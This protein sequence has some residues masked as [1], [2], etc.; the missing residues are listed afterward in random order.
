MKISELNIFRFT[1]ALRQPLVIGKHGLTERTGLIVKLHTENDHV[2]LGEI[3]P[4]PGLSRETMTQ[5]EAEIA[6]LRS[7]VTGRDMPDNLEEL[8]GGFDR[9]L[10]GYNMAPSVRFGFETACLNLMAVAQGVPLC[11]LISE[12]SRDSI[13][14]N[15][16]LTGSHNEIMDK[17]ARLLDMGY[18]AFK[19][20]VGRSSVRQDAE[21][22]LAIRGLI[23]DSAL[24]RLDANRAW[25]I[26]DALAFDHAVAGHKIDYIEEPVRSLSLLKKLINETGVS[27]PIALDESLLELTSQALASLSRIVAIVLKPTL[28][29]LEKAVQV[30][31]AATGLGITPVV[32]SSFESGVGLKTLAHMAAAV[33]VTDV[34]AGL[35]T[36]DWFEEDLLIHP[37][38]IEKGRLRVTETP[39][40]P[41][42][43]RL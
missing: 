1:L 37:L 6:R 13:S 35:D 29:G 23:G 30:A 42:E 21:T 40:S 15:G 19:L 9:W 2:A 36:L 31:R 12:S 3:S 8:S 4:L 27:L 28:W 7:L 24:L 43:I 41:F 16:L 39:C 18:T 14:V 11:K 5:A 25:S 17:A 22:T 32:S 38:R 10:G 33:N 34:P 26:D 20:K